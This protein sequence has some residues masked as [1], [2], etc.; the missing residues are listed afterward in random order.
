[1]KRIQASTK[2]RDSTWLISYFRPN[3]ST[4][5]VGILVDVIGREARRLA[6]SGVEK[7]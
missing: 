1:M 6:N 5:A 2:R 4:L 3:S 7:K